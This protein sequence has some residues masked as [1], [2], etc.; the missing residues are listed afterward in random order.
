MYADGSG[1]LVPVQEIVGAWRIAIAERHRAQVQTLDWHLLHHLVSGRY[2]LSIN[3]VELAVQ[4]GDLIY[5]PPHADVVWLENVGPVVFHS[6]AFHAP[7]LTIEP[8]PRL[9]RDAAGFGKRLSTMTEERL[10]GPV[11]AR[12]SLLHWATLLEVVALLVPDAPEAVAGG[13]QWNGLEAYIRRSGDWQMPTDAMARW[14]GC[15]RTTLHRHCLAATGLAPGAW[16][17]QQRHDLARRMLLTS[18][19]SISAIARQLGYARVQEFS[20]DFR[21]LAGQPPARWRQ[22]AAQEGMAPEPAE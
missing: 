14:L 4:P 17:R 16:L 6:V 22:L 8:R 12:Q 18:A 13:S 21:R 15:S 2:R 7:G 3:G 5:Y 20:R 11:S 9:L 19:M 1:G 10:L